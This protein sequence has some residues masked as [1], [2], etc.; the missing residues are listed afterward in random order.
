MDSSLPTATLDSSPY[1]AV[2]PPEYDEAVGR[3]ARSERELSLERHVANLIS[4]ISDER[5]TAV[6]QSQ[7]V[8]F[9][10]DQRDE[11]TRRHRR[12]EKAA[13]QRLLALKAVQ[14]RLGVQTARNVQL[15]EYGLRLARADASSQLS[16]L[17]LFNLQLLTSEIQRIHHVGKHNNEPNMVNASV[18]L[19]EIVYAME[20]QRFCLESARIS[21]MGPAEATR[22]EEEL[23]AQL[24]VHK[25]PTVAE[26]MDQSSF[27]VVPSNRVVPF[28]LFDAA[29]AQ[30]QVPGVAPAA[31]PVP[32]SSRASTLSDGSSSPEGAPVAGPVA[33]SRHGPAY[34]V[35]G[36]GRTLLR[37]RVHTPSSTNS[38]WS[39][40]SDDLVYPQDD[41]RSPSP[42]ELEGN[43]RSSTPGGYS[44]QG[45]AGIRS[46]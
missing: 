1:T 28:S 43:S 8:R 26:L 38:H 5:E 30:Y 37:P 41:H 32:V 24:A 7:R 45:S 13:Y 18:R 4:E 10:M 16:N 15:A 36:R 31:A 27:R 14:A 17:I 46:P 20:L 34:A 44:E 23:V 42:M 33:P 35:R 22:R 25:F 39:F 19:E 40:S 11:A 21:I 2:A 9:Y 3:P 12:A 29:A 6:L